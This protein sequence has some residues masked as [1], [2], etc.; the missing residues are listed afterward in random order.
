MPLASARL[1]LP[2]SLEKQAVS[3]D[4]F[5]LRCGGRRHAFYLRQMLIAPRGDS[6]TAAAA[7]AAAAVYSNYHRILC[8]GV[9]GSRAQWRGGEVN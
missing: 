1:T 3:W 5:S 9:G 4:F 6:V 8:D 2:P 7:A